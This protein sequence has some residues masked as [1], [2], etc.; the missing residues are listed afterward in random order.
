MAWQTV[1]GLKGKVFVPE[2]RSKGKKK[3][4][5][6]DCFACQQCSE[7]RCRVCFG[8]QGSFAASPHC[9]CSEIQEVK[10]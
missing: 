9:V 4:P 8:H 10:Q 6:P 2:S 3:N 1:P 5:C 7:E